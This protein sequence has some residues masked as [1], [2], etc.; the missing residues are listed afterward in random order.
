MWKLLLGLGAVLLMAAGGVYVANE[1]DVSKRRASAEEVDRKST[2]LNR[3]LHQFG[4]PEFKIYDSAS[5]VHVDHTA[6]WFLAGAGTLSIIVGLA[7]AGK[8]V[9][10]NNAVPPIS[11]RA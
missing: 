2:N 10:D 1:G 3:S 7:V 6:S 8:S 11:W 5:K 4:S 9:P